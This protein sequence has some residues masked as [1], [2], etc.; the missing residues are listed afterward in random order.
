MNQFNRLPK[1]TLGDACNGCGYCCTTEPCSLA[2]EF[3]RCTRGPCVALEAAD[4]KAVCG[5]VRNPLGYLYQAARPGEA[6]FALAPAPAV[7][8]GH[9][10]AVEIAAALGIGKGCDADD[11]EVSAAWPSSGAAR[12]LGRTFPHV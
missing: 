4:G 9:Q 8:A 5:L 6:S 10:L 7:H 12:V 2:Q 11:D 1:P 3:L